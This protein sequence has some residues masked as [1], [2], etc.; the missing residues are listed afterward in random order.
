MSRN[1]RHNTIQI[2]VG[3][4]LLCRSELDVPLCLSRILWKR[5]QGTRNENAMIIVLEATAGIC[6]SIA[7]CSKF[8][9]SLLFLEFFSLGSLVLFDDLF[10]LGGGGILRIQLS[11]RRKSGE[12]DRLNP[13]PLRPWAGSSS[14]HGRSWRQWPLQCC[15][16]SESDGQEV[17]NETKHP[18]DQ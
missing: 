8:W 4:T 5:F 10:S 11:D 3:V 9:L 14:E 2:S 1:S 18:I 13:S 15:T 17:R 7:A 6:H 16:F 12:V